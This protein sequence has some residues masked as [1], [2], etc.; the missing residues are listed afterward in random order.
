MGRLSDIID[1]RLKE[2]KI[3]GS[4]MC[5]DLGMS[6]ST[7]T[8]LRKGRAVTLKAEKAAAIAAYLGLSVEELLGKEKAPIPEGGRKAGKEELMAAFWG[9]DKDLSPEDMD[10][11]WQDVENFA[12]FVAQKKK[13]EKRK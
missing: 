4:K 6:R 1:A 3:P 11:M 2:L 9:G 12:A 5:D 10:A 13:E 8:E 7:L